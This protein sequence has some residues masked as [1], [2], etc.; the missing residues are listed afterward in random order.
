MR[1]KKLLL[2]KRFFAAAMAAAMTVSGLPAAGYAAEK[3]GSEEV[4]YFVDCG[5]YVTSTVCSGDKM[6]SCNSVTDQV[7]GKDPSTGYEWGVVDT[8]SDPLKNSTSN[9]GGVD[10]DHT[11]AFESNAANQDVA[12]KVNSNRYTKNQLEQGI[13]V[14]YIDYKFQLKAGEY[15]VETC[16]ADPWSCSK[17]PSLYMDTTGKT[18]EEITDNFKKDKGLVLAAGTP[19]KQNVKLDADG[20]LTVSFRGTGNDNKAINVNYIKIT[21]PIVVDEESL[22]SED[23]EAIYFPSTYIADDQLDLPTKGTNGSDITWTSS[24]PGV[25]SEKGKVTHPKEGE[26]DAVVRLTAQVKNGDAVFTKT[27][28]FTVYAKKAIGEAGQFELDQVE[29]LDPYYKQ[30]QTSDI[31][32]LKKFDNDRILSRF[33][34]TAGLSTN[35]AKPYNGWENSYIGGHCLGHYFTACAQAVK[36][37]GDQDLKQK[38]DQLMT[39]LRKCQ[40]KLGTGFI[41]ASQ[42]EDPSNVE[43]QFNIVEGKDE[44]ST[45]VPWYTMHKIVQGLID[46]YRYAGNEEALTIAKDLGEW[47]YK[48]VIAWDNDTRNRILW[49]EYGGMNDCMYELYEITGNTHY[50][51]AAHQFD[52]PN[53]YQKILSGESNTLN[54]RHANATIPKFIGALNRYQSL[55]ARGDSLSA[56]DKKYLGYAEGFWKLVTEKHA[57]ITGGVSDMEH[58]KQDN[59]QDSIRTQCDCESCCAHNLLRL[60]KELFKL[61]G[62]K[63]YADYY[64]NTLRNAIMGSINPENGTTTYFTPMATGYY[65]YFGKADPAENMFWCCTGTGMENF[66]KLGDSIYFHAGNALIV[67]QYVSSSVKWT[68]KKIQVTQTADVTKSE[69]AEFAVKLLD[70]ASNVSMKL[71]LKVP[72][73]IAGA[74]KILVNGKETEAVTSGGYICVDRTW[75]DGDKVVM[76]YP[77]KVTA[78]RL[79]DNSKAYAFMY[80]PTVLAAKLGTDKWNDV[81]WAGANL[82]AAAYKVVGSESVRLSVTYGQTTKQILGTETMNIQGDQTI[83]EFMSDI[84]SHMVRDTSKDTLSFKIQGTDADTTFKSGLEFVPFNTLNKER[85]GIYWY[86]NGADEQAA[87]SLLESKEEGRFAASIIDSIQPG[88]GQYENDAVHSLKENNTV[89]GEMTD[90]GSTRY[91]KKGGYFEYRM[92]VHKG[93]KNS[94]LCQYVKEDNG[95]SIKITVDGKQLASEKLAYDGD[96]T[97]YKKY[98]EL[99]DEIVA[100]AKS[101]EVGGEKYDL[102][103]V[104]FESADAN[105]DSARLA[106][107]LMMTKAYGTEAVIETVESESGQVKMDGKE[108]TVTVSAGTKLAKLNFALLEK[109]GLLYVGDQLV[110]DSKIQEFEVGKEAIKLKVFAEDHETSTEYTLKFVEESSTPAD[111]TNPTNPTNPTDPTN[112]NNPTNPSNSSDVKGNGS[113]PATP[114]ALAT[115]AAAVTKGST[116]TVGDYVYTVTDVAGKT[117]AVTGVKNQKIG[118]INI[119]NTVTIANMV[120]KITEIGNSAFAGC[121]SAKSAVVGANIT[122]IGSKAFFNCKKLKKITIKGK[123][124][125]KVGKNA[126]KRINKKAVIKVPKKQYKKYKKLLKK[127]GQNKKVKIKK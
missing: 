105:A 15:T 32:F 11:W 99:P 76:T 41:F 68:D 66:T 10:T 83:E 50:R 102:V 25:I 63:K 9:K 77:M 122:K 81:T 3:K 78:H 127:K 59:A 113:K 7:F 82:E 86:F 89:F 115:P 104:R 22:A 43:K 92:I 38:L 40:T 28:D 48:R 60:S 106:A 54:Q 91:A 97:L 93:Q 20:Y 95:K 34:E 103:T 39:E 123:N 90:V 14:R 126:F 4:F 16:T 1:R 100:A 80:G 26:E 56:D 75:S 62:D 74:P 125:K 53:L 101:T 47:I 24:K 31:A 2:S 52:D 29:V 114:A 64:E 118:K 70:G 79:P 71:Y 117:V 37:A 116:Y 112:P 96:E 67:N 109:M 110:N 46:V 23:M 108:I 19:V 30:A 94:L 42:I 65:K 13:E 57:F 107:G 17:S 6:G 55:M 69:Q 121:K 8:V 18:A 21:E 5:D 120:C 49:S 61:T 33:R 73:W 35:G 36:T 12:S 88:Y 84:S 27:F 72:D 124:L 87:S 98:Y 51:D 45:W 85:Y 119:G 58:F 111:P 44:G